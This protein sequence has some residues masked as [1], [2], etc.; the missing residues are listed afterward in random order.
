[1]QRHGRKMSCA[2]GRKNNGGWV[3]A[4]LQVVASSSSILERRT[5][6]TSH[7]FWDVIVDGAGSVG[8]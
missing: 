2:W 8:K 5:N 3:E 7:N 6:R 4:E 1:M